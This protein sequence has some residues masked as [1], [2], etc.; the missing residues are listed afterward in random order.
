MTAV[1]HA[2]ASSAAASA[3]PLRRAHALAVAHGAVGARRQRDRVLVDSLRLEEGSDGLRH[4]DLAGIQRAR[5]LAATGQVACE[6]GASNVTVAQVVER[7]G[8]S[9]RTFYEVFTDAEDCMSAALEEALRRAQERTIAAWRTEGG[10]RER[11]RRC[12]VELLGLFDKD[13]VLAQLLV[14]ESLSANRSVL[15]ERLRVLD[16]IVEAIDGAARGEVDMTGRDM[17]LSAEGAIGGMLGV[18]HTRISRQAPGLLTD[19]VGPLMGMLV[20]PYHGAAAARRELSRP[21]PA[22]LDR[23]PQEDEAPL[24]SDPFKDAGMRLTYRTTRVLDVIAD[25]PGS[26]NRKIGE[27]AGIGDQGQ[28]S[29]LLSRLE[30][31]GMVANDG[32]GAGRGEPNSWSLTVAGRQLIRN[33]RS[34]TEQQP[35]VK[36]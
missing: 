5:L 30:R 27:L 10:W 6:R 24:L 36:A 32:E 15:Q 18:L 1:T 17:R 9:R 25:S 31:V 11:T 2:V 4:S 3:A 14:V 12:L 26:S 23:T 13:P 21:L 34:H 35:R 22:A 8:V 20:L 33:L 19:L 28:V 16:A 29:K 7:A